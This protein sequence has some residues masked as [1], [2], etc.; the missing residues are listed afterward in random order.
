MATVRSV[1]PGTE[2]ARSPLEW[3]LAHAG[4]V[5]LLM[6]AVTTMTAVAAVRGVASELGVTVGD[7]ALD[8]RGAVVMAALWVLA[9]ASFALPHVIRVVVRPRN[10]WQ[11]LVTTALPALAI[12][13]FVNRLLLTG[14]APWTMACVVLANEAIVVAATIATWRRGITAWRSEFDANNSAFNAEV[15]QIQKLNKQVAAEMLALKPDRSL[16]DRN[17]AEVQAQVDRLADRDNANLDRS[18]ARL[19]RLASRGPRLLAATTA[20]M[21]GAASPL[22]AHEASQQWAASLLNHPDAANAT[23]LP[24]SIAFSSMVGTATLDDG[25]SSCVLRVGGDVFVAV[26]AV[27]VERRWVAFTVEDCELDEVPFRD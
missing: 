9:P 1:T 5:A 10:V 21:I 11:L 3:L 8:S 19:D 17:L 18:S 13:V 15:A 24:L 4:A 12:V 16:I 7:L 23:P 2:F 20:L 25:T 27:A 22:L 6:T 14:Y 26:E